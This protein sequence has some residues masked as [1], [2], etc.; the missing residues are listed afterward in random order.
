MK[1]VHKQE[2]STEGN[3]QQAVKDILHASNLIKKH[4]EN[5]LARFDIN[6]QKFY[7]LQILSKEFPNHLS[8]SRIKNK[9]TDKTIDLSRIM[10]QMD[11][12]GLVNHIRQIGNKRVSEITITTRGMEVLNEI[13]ECSDEMHAGMAFVTAHEATQ[14]VEIMRRIVARLRELSQQSDTMIDEVNSFAKATD[15]DNTAA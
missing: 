8:Q 14:I 2:I 9:L 10:K 6:L 1:V 12:I 3:D 7:I 13:E 5:I 15:W 4:Q 11:G